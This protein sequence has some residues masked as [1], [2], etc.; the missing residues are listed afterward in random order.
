MTAKLKVIFML[1][2]SG[3]LLGALP[4]TWLYG[5][6]DEQADPSHQDEMASVSVQF[7]LVQIERDTLE[8]LMNEANTPTLDSI[9]LERIGRCVRE[10][11]GAEIVSQ[12]RLAVV[13][14]FEA[15]MIVADNEHNLAKHPPEEDSE[16]AHRETEVSI[17]MKIER[18]DGHRLAARFA[19]D[20]TVTME[21]Y[22][23]DPKEEQEEG[24]ERKF[25]LSSGIVLHAGR[26]HLVGA[27]LSEDMATLLLMKAEL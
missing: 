5:A 8:R 17:V 4:V 13:S 24:I 15:K 19:Y 1:A 27:S 20:R 6:N 16:N 10:K 25:S 23:Q 9:P 21:A 26:M 12:T 7:M 2:L 22:V 3:L 18:R 11:D 14:G